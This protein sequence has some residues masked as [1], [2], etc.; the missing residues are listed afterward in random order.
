MAANVDP[1]GITTKTPGVLIDPGDAA[2]NLIG[3]GHQV[4]ACLDDVVEVEHSK[5]SA[6]VD[7]HLG[8]MS[9]AL[10]QS[11]APSAAMHK[12]ID[13]RVPSL[14]RIEIKRLDRCRPVGEPLRRA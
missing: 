13:R 3:H 2:A 8:V 1:L 4:S 11:S 14:G 7:E 12:D 6:G 5:M 10:R 9:I